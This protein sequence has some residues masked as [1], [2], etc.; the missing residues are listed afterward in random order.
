MQWFY[1]GSPMKTFS[2]LDWL[3]EEVLL[4]Q[5]IQLEDFIGFHTKREA[6]HLDNINIHLSAKD[7]WIETSVSIALPAEQVPF[8]SELDVP[9]FTVSGL[10]YKKPLEVMKAALQSD[11]ANQFHQTPFYEYCNL[12][13][14]ATPEHIYSEIYSANAFIEED[15]HIREA[16]ASG[17]TPE[18]ETVLCAF[19]LY[20]DS[21]HLT[22]FGSASLWPIYAFFWE[23]VKIFSLQKV[24]PCY[25]PSSLYSQSIS[26]Q[27]YI[28]LFHLLI[29]V[30]L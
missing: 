10:Y 4:R 22:N 1:S 3:V 18:I 26:S 8:K 28:F 30:L 14:D 13:S 9:R 17:P 24:R 12:D 5:D 20:S 6:N 29:L 2:E 19:I 7:G 27:L 11:T 15:L 25:I 23:Y 16:N 21:T